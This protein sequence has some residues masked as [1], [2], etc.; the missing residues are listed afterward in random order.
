VKTILCFGD[1]NTWGCVPLTG[2]GPPRR[3]GPSQRWPG[4]APAHQ[5]PGAVLAEEVRKLLA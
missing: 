2:P 4:D 1:S 3:Y 5:R